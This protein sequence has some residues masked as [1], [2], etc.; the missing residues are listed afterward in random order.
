MQ[1]LLFP[2]SEILLEKKI[3]ILSLGWHGTN[4][5]KYIGLIMMKDFY[6]SS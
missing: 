1:H 4:S 5:G 6:I 2:F 3:T